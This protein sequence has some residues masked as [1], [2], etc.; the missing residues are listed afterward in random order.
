MLYFVLVMFAALPIHAVGVATS[1]SKG[2]AKASTTAAIEQ[3]DM[4][5]KKG[6]RKEKM[7]QFLKQQLAH[8]TVAGVVA[9]L[10]VLVAIISSLVCL[11]HALERRYLEKK[12]RE[13]LEK[14]LEGVE[15]EAPCWSCVEKLGDQEPVCLNSK[16]EKANIH[17]QCTICEE[18]MI[19]KS[20]D[21]KSNDE[22]TYQH[23]V[24]PCCGFESICLECKNEY[25][26][27]TEKGECPSC[28]ANI[29]NKKITIGKKEF[30]KTAAAPTTKGTT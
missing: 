4:P 19:D 1:T 28:R 2:E 22:R 26:G 5:G 9:A 16:C 12:L 25:Y 14:T 24:F 29:D 8:P 3:K 18:R 7:K 15:V 10:L 27:E 6:T 13:F 23:A 11:Y 21:E 20:N 17:L 30:S